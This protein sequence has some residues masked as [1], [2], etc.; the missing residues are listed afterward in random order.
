MKR[1]GAGV[2]PWSIL[3][4]VKK[5]SV[6]PSDSEKMFLGCNTCFWYLQWFCL[7][8]DRDEECGA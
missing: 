2:S 4:L 7:A 3:I 1:Y 8:G 6:A 5:E